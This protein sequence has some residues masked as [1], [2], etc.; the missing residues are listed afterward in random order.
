[1]QYLECSS[2]FIFGI[3]ELHFPLLPGLK[4]F[5]LNW[6]MLKQIDLTI[7]WHFFVYNALGVPKIAC[8]NTSKE[9]VRQWLLHACVFIY[10]SLWWDIHIYPVWSGCDQ[11]CLGMPKF[12]P[13]VSQLY[14]NN[15]LSYKFGFLHV[16]RDP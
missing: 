11:I 4:L 12:C 6:P 13:I 14:V 8:L 5:L 2:V 7:F 3:Y 15:K 16:N 1:M 10:Q 9:P